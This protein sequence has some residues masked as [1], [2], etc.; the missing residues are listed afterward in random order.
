MKQYYPEI[1]AVKGI[2]ILLVILGHS[3]CSFPINVGAEFPVLSEYVRSFQMPLFFIASGFLFSTEGRF[4]EFAKKKAWRLIVPWL[5]FSIL[6][7][8]LKVAF[9]SVTRHGAIGMST[10]L[11]DIVQ[12][13][14]YWFLYALTIIMVVCRLARSKWVLGGL[15]IASVIACEASDIRSIH[16]FE[17]GRIVFYFPIFC[18]GMLIKHVYAQVAACSVRNIAIVTLV[19]MAVFVVS[20]QNFID[21]M[22][23]LPALSGSIMT[24]G[25]VLLLRRYK[26]AALRHFGHYSLQYYLN[27][28]LIMLP[29]YYAAKP[30][31][32][33]YYNY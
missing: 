25:I 1:D 17:L 33:P 18:L 23:Y 6:S 15:C 26:M 27:H 11:L 22:D 24:W 2:A 29:C 30:I 21:V 19:S 9:S 7:L 12:G 31:A 3:F 16:A 4:V 10:A 5:A 28:L 32:P 13:H 14:C 20:M 8:T